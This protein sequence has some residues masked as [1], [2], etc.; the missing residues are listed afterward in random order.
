MKPKIRLIIEE[1]VETG[2]VRGYRKAHKHVENPS[3]DAIL[4]S[5]QDCIMAELITYFT[6]EK[7]DYA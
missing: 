6:F 3:E 1:C 5:I 4:T 7:E 2:S